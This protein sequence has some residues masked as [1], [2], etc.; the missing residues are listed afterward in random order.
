M[1]ETRIKRHASA[2]ASFIR[3]LVEFYGLILWEGKLKLNCLT[4]QVLIRFGFEK[5]SWARK[6]VEGYV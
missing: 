6:K 2:G 5:N 1:E 4:N 3:Q